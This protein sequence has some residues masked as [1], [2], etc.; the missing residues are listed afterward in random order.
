MFAS[1]RCRTSTTLAVVVCLLVA[2]RRRDYDEQPTSLVALAPAALSTTSLTP[3]NHGKEVN[4]AIANLSIKTIYRTIRT[5]RPEKLQRVDDY[6]ITTCRERLKPSDLLSELVVCLS[7]D[8]VD[9]C[10]RSLRR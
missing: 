9:K 6:A 4:A 8:S 1:W 3:S 2:S 10:E 7:A 5:Y